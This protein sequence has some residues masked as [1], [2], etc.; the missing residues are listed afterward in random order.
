MI[1]GSDDVLM[2]IFF[3]YRKEFSTA[4]GICKKHQENRGL[5]ETS[6]HHEP[7]FR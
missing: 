3:P 1:G 2:P 4:N 6:A 7:L 5:N